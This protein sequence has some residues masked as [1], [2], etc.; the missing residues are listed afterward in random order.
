MRSIGTDGV[1]AAEN[2][3]DIVIRAQ[4]SG[5]HASSGS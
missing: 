5:K 1:P 4:R 2:L 3:S